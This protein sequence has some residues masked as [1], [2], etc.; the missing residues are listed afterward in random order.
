MKLIVNADD[1]GYTPGVTRG[2]VRAHREGIVT[3][4]TLMA[5]AP[6][7]D[8]A[9]S[10]AR[11]TRSLDVGVH[12]VYTYGRPLSP[13]DAVPSL[14]S[15]GAFRRPD[16][17]VRTGAP[18]AAEA[19]REAR[20]QYARVRALIGREPTHVDTHHWVHDLP[21]LEEALVALGRETGAAVRAQSDAQRA[22]LR[23]AGI[24]TTDRFVRDFQHAGHIGP[25]ELIA[26][27][28]DVCTGEGV[29]ELMCHPGEVDAALLGLSTYARERE[30]ELATL[31][32]PRVRDTVA[33]LGIRLVTFATGAAV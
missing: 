3:A 25:D 27:L 26:L 5:N 29:A 2:I 21:A 8:G 6:D 17:L 33:R 10:A 24:R 7:S 1:F 31:I 9:G 15:G 14:L 11:E 22:R 13:A 18:N 28:E 12:V 32:E 23:A 19:L 20:A 16:D 4:T 30:S